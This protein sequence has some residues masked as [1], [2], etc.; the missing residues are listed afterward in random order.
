MA[1]S[2]FDMYATQWCDQ[3]LV[4]VD[5][6]GE[7]L[8]LG[9]DSVWDC[10]P[11]W[12]DTWLS[13]QRSPR[14]PG[15]PRATFSSPKATDIYKFSGGA[16]T[17]FATSTCN[18]RAD[19]Q[20]AYVRPCGHIWEQN[21]R[22]VIESGATYTIDGRWKC[23]VH[24][25]SGQRRY[26]EGPAIPPLS[27]GPL[28][29]QILVADEHNGQVHA[30]K[31]DGTVT[32]NAFNWSPPLG[33]GAENV[34]VIPSIPCTF[35]CTNGTFFQ[36][37]Y[38]LDYIIY[39][40]PTDFQ[41]LGGN[42][43]VTSEA[44]PPETAMGTVLVRFNAET[45]TYDTTLF[46]GTFSSTINEGAYFVDCDVPS[47]ITPCALASCTPPYPFVSENPRTNV[48]F[49]ESEVLRGFRMAVDA[50]CIPQTL[51]MFYNDEHAMTL[52]VN[53][54]QVASSCG[55]DHN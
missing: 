53:Q 19:P 2:R 35:G 43:I 22:N 4:G 1:V 30:I 52:G 31:N 29:G 42:V 25:G 44:E 14:T 48:A 50:N 15:S 37:I 32:R 6:H 46:D 9:D 3:S 26:T 47:V 41:G 18:F 45:Q 24:R 5:C 10:V 16:I 23:H 40:P 49:N 34:N 51:Q 54:V 27:F 36:M 8:D 38:Y 21:D 39:Y 55:T 12:K 11:A 28:G 20:L 7:C 13:L 33:K 17:F